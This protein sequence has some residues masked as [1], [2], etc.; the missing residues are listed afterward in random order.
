M[1]VQVSKKDNW[2]H[3]RRRELRAGRRTADKLE[4][5]LKA[6]SLYR[7]TMKAM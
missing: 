1:S 5:I 4:R 6:E 7:L 2:E 3:L